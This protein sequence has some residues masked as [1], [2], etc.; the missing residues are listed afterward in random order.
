MSPEDYKFLK[1]LLVK[2]Y[3]HKQG[4][5]VSG[6]FCDALNEEIIGKLDSCID[7]AEKNGRKTLYDYDL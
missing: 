4:F 6:A 2:Q 7:K 1:K 5:K 3:I